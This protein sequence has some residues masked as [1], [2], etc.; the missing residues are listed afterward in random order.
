MLKYFILTILIPSFVAAKSVGKV[1]F[2][3]GKA[4][5]DS[6]ILNKGAP[7]NEGQVIKTE[8]RS[9]VRVKFIDDSTMT[10]GPKSEVKVAKFKPGQ[11]GVISLLKGKIRS[12]VK[13]TGDKDKMYVKTPTAAMGVRGTDYQITYNP[14]TEKSAVVTFEGNVAF[15]QI[16][17]KGTK[18]KNF[19]SY[20]RGTTA[21]SVDP[22]MYSGTD[23]KLKRTSLPTRISPVQYS[24]LKR[25]DDFKDTTKKKT[26]S[27]RSIV[28]A[29]LSQ[30]LFINENVEITQVAQELNIQ[31]DRP[32]RTNTPPPEGFFDN[33]TK[34][35][36]PPAGGYVSENGDYVAPV[37]GQATFDPVTETYTPNANFGGVDIATGNYIPPQGYELTE[38]G[39]FVPEGTII[40]EGQ[41]N[42]NFNQKPGAMEGP[43]LADSGNIGDFDTAF[44]QGFN[45]DI[46]NDEF[47]AFNEFQERQRQDSLGEDL[48]VQI[49]QNGQFGSGD[50]F[51]TVIFNINIQ[52]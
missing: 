11:P 26:V 2:V 45:P 27:A 30:N 5:V 1:V 22:G 18:P 38:A 24:S 34:E 32:V 42:Q 41:A 35:F 13:K 15:R 48:E 25:N 12:Q 7:L 47:L 23:N 29:G 39:T 28:P 44:G 9:V 20:L 4:T 49:E 8:K 51:T 21:V 37:P 31:A 43:K 3:R 16:N 40:V 46:K 10:I 19:G 6:S 33:K 14:K 17:K 50:N 36:A 52:P